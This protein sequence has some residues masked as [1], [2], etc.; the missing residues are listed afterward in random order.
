MPM[1]TRR[2]DGLIRLPMRFRALEVLSHR[3]LNQPQDQQCDWNVDAPEYGTENH[4]ASSE[5][6]SLSALQIWL[7]AVGSM[8]DA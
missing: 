8:H 7:L 3:V 2:R 4:G 6:P 1:P 5:A